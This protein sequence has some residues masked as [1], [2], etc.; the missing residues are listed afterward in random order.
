MGVPT[1]S[2]G[3][4]LY[5]MLRPFVANLRYLVLPFLLF[6][7]AGCGGREI[8]TGSASILQ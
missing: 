8:G 5:G 3:D 4:I 6:T 7:S 2:L 1:A